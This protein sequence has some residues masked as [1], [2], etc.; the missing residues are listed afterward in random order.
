MNFSYYP[1]KADKLF[2]HIEKFESK[3]VVDGEGLITVFENTT[4]VIMLYYDYLN[5]VA[6]E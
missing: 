3:F 6:S 2:K 1:F 5:M 4:E